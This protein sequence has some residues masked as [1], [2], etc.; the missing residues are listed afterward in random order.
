MTIEVNAN[1]ETIVPYY[2]GRSDHSQTDI[3]LA[4]VIAYDRVLSDE[5][6]TM[7]EGYLSEKYNLDLPDGAVL[8]QSGLLGNDTDDDGPHRSGVVKQ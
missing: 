8:P 7:V 6:R 4:E 1:S 5:E 2:L 3:E